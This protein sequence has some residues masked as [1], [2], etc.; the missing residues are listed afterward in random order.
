MFYFYRIVKTF[1]TTIL[2]LH[3]NIQSIRIKYIF[4]KSQ[5]NCDILYIFEK[6]NKQI[7]TWDRRRH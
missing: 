5:N 4:Q 6:K 7:N 3:E 2:N 1:K